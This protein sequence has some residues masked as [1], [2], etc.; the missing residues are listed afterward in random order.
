MAQL[1]RFRFL[2]SF[3]V[4][5]ASKLRADV[6]ETHKVAEVIQ[7]I[8]IIVV[9]LMYDGNKNVSVSSVY[10]EIIYA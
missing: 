1:N 4:N 8:F 6:V 2:N 10:L 7:S 5:G 9:I 3:M